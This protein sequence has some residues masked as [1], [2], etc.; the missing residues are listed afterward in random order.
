MHG[1]KSAILAIFR[2]RLIGWIGYAL[3][4]QPSKTAHRIFFPFYIQNF[5]SFFKYETI[6]IVRRSAWSCSHSDPDPCSA[7][8]EAFYIWEIIIEVTFNQDKCFSTHKHKSN[9]KH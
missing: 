9:F 1:L 5:T 2:N 6:A 3:L 8:N 4:V 7:L